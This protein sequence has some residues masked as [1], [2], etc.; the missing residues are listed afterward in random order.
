MVDVEVVVVVVLVV[1]VVV[2]GAQTKPFAVPTHSVVQQVPWALRQAFAE[3]L[4][5]GQQ[6]SSATHCVPAEQQALSQHC[7]AVAQQ[8]GPHLFGAAGG[9][10]QVPPLGIWLP[11]HLTGVGVGLGRRAASLSPSSIGP[12]ATTPPPSPSRPLSRERRLV[13]VAIDFT[14]ESNVRS[15]M[16]KLPVSNARQ[17][18]VEG[19]YVELSPDQHLISRSAHGLGCVRGARSRE[20]DSCGVF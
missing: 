14:S 3:P 19:R 18:D 6:I 8:A 5:G 15:S 20:P 16:P 1:V 13:P 10:M 4:G 7:V 12:P 11:G 2:G 17:N 9:Q